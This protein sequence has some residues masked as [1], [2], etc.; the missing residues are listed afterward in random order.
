M[1]GRRII[2][3]GAVDPTWGHRKQMWTFGMWYFSFLDFLFTG[4]VCPKLPY[5]CLFVMVL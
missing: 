1:K 2:S 5:T 3:S 4:Q